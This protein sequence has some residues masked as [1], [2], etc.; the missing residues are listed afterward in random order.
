M[1]MWDSKSWCDVLLTEHMCYIFPIYLVYVSQGDVEIK[2]F[3]YESSAYS[4]SLET[5]E[6]H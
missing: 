2:V 4:V 5:K 3:F 6:W 1:S